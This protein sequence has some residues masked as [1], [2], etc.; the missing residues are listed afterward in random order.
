MNEKNIKNDLKLENSNDTVILSKEE[1]EKLKRFEGETLK[2][3]KCDFALIVNSGAALPTTHPNYNN[4]RIKIEIFDI[5]NNNIEI[6]GKKYNI[7][8][9]VL[10]NKIKD[11]IRDNLNVLIDWSKKETNFYLNSNVYEDGNSKNIKVK[12]G[13]LL[14]N[15]DGQITGNLGKNIDEFI[16]CLKDLILKEIDKGDKDYM[17]DIISNIPEQTNDEEFE[18]YCKLYEEKFGK[19]VYIPEPNGTKEFVIECIKK[20]LQENKDV[21][22]ELYYPKDDAIY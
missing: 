20:C 18:K 8:T 13:Q 12:Y 5:N 19:K 3:Q 10:F 9:Q 16:N 11:F 21:L 1:Y 6:D 2:I 4:G 14:I 22:D 15:V 17:M 7:K